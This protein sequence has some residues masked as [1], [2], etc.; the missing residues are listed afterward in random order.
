MT[1]EYSV[2]KI[3]IEYNEN[4]DS[5]SLVEFYETLA[6]WN[7]Q[8]LR[9]VSQVSQEAANDVLLIKEI[10]QGSIDINLVSSLVPLINDYNTV[11]SFFTSIKSIFTWLSTKVGTKPKMEIDDLRNTKKIIAPVNNHSGRQINISIDGDNNAPIIIDNA[12]AKEMLSNADEELGKLIEPPKLLE[13]DEIKKNVVLKLKQIRDSENNTKNNKGII[14]E[15]ENKE[16]PIMFV[17]PELADSVLHAINNPL[18][19]NYLVD[20]KIHKT[21]EKINSY[22]IL[23]LHDF[24]IDEEDQ[25]EGDLFS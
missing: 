22:T 3:K 16:Y 23:Q 8:Y 19:K 12:I 18:L 5:I 25:M 17:T 13:T 24:Y 1:N 4:K 21:N 9:C 15:I 10:K 20:V 7:N 14:Q 2:L 11:F 6:G